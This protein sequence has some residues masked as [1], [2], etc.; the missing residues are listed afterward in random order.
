[1]MAT[2]MRERGDA[3]NITPKLSGTWQRWFLAAFL[4]VACFAAVRPADAQIVIVDHH[5]HH[6]HHYHHHHHR[7]HRHP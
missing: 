6:H 1:M 4:L 2:G 5:H 3:V 7:Y